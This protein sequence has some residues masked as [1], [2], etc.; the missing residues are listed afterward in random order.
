MGAGTVTISKEY[1]AKQAEGTIDLNFMFSTG[2]TQKLVV[3]ISDTTP[4]IVTVSYLPGEHGTIDGSIEQVVIGGHPVNV[5]VVTPAKGYHF[6]GWSSD[7]GITKLSS[8]EVAT[9]LVAADVT[10]TAQYT[11]FVMGMQMATVK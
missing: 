2:A 6:A 1:L 11:A 9:S 4:K 7:G 5:P 8:H 10:Y 3:T